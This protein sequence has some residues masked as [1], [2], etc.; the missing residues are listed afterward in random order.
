MNVAERIVHRQ[1]RSLEERATLAQ[2]CMLRLELEMPML[3]DSLDDE[4][5]RKYCA[6]PDRLYL[7]DEQGIVL[8]R[9]GIG[10]FGFR[11]G[12]WERAIER[13]IRPRLP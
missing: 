6:A 2:A 9:S 5:E 10:P 13:A 1:P 12:P 4:V 11:V 8:H 3:L 7:L